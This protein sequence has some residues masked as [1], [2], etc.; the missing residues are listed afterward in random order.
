MRVFKLS[1]IFSIFF[2]SALFLTSCGSNQTED[3]SFNQP[4]PY[5]VEQGADLAK[6]NFDLQT[7]GNLLERAKNAEE[8]ENLINSEDG[9]NNLDLNGDGY[10]D[11]ISVSEFDDRYQ[12]QRGFVLYDRFGPDDIQEVCRIIFDRDRY[13]EP[14]ARVLLVGNEQIYGDDYYYETNWLD[15]PLTI[16]NWIFSDRDVN[17]ESPYYYE[18]YPDYYENYEV[19]ETPVYHTRI[20]NYYYAPVFVKTDSPTI[21][22]IKIK[23]HYQDRTSER[24]VARLVNPTRE[25]MEFRKNNP[26]YFEVSRVKNGKDKE[27]RSRGNDKFENR[28]D[29]DFGRFENRP[30]KNYGKFENPRNDRNEKFEE[31]N[32]PER[33]ER[34]NNRP[35]RV[36]RENNRPERV[37]RENNQPER[38][39][40]G[41]N[42]AERPQRVERENVRPNKPERVER[43]NIPD[44]RMD[45]PNRVERGNISPNKPNK[46][47]NE[48]RQQGGNGQN[49]SRSNNG[50]NG[51]NRGNGGGKKGKP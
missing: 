6:D 51:G 13:D 30:D 41:N 46:P 32:R 44:V 20:Q 11:Y 48:V 5:T 31:R 42:R 33:I 4:Y 16:A 23:S 38:F 25:Q 17:Y 14:G 29:K 50:N 3:T 19:V 24:I 12:D 26:E 36:E 15:K 27:F 47:G 39:Q 18:N 8:F 1:L 37:E 49:Q 7:V 28:A 40:R 35:E 45:R 9:V 22:Q 34:G 43:Q 10:A 2:I 21:T